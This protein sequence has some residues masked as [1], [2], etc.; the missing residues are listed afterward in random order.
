MDDLIETEELDEFGD[1]AGP[2]VA[3]RIGTALAFPILLALIGAAVLISIALYSGPKIPL[4]TS[5]SFIDSIFASRTLVGSAR[6]MLLFGA[7]YVVLSIVV[8]IGR[9]QWLTKFGPIEVSESVAGIAHERDALAEQLEE[10]RQTIDA[11]EDRLIE[12]NAAYEETTEALSSTLDYISRLSEEGD[13][14]D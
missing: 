12:T 7:G 13:D 8:L 14:R 9:Q 6:I 11:L 4:G 2:T 3:E 5:P 1:A 10:A